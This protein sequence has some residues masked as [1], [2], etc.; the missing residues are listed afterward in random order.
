MHYTI[1]THPHYTHMHIYT[2][3]HLLIL[4][5]QGLQNK[6]RLGNMRYRIPFLVGHIDVIVG[7]QPLT[8]QLQALMVTI[9]G[10][11]MQASVGIIAGGSGGSS[12]R[13][14]SSVI[15]IGSWP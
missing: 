1:Y 12:G 13:P 11:D 8:H 9:H 14:S 3:I 5:I 4:T 15:V 2:Y 10:S 7:G 6:S